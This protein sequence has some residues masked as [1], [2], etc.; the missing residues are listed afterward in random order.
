MP[1]HRGGFASCR[2][3]S[4]RETRRWTFRRRVPEG[5]LAV[6]S[7][8]EMWP[9]MADAQGERNNKHRALDAV[10]H[11]HATVT[12]QSTRAVGANGAGLNRCVQCD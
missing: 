4:S 8:I 6:S 7:A 1:A 5:V 9:G 2:R 12:S 3:R 10:Q 11:C